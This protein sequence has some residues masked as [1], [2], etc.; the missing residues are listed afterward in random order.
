MIFRT[1]IGIYTIRAI[2]TT[3]ATRVIGIPQSCDIYIY[4]YTLRVLIGGM[5]ATESGKRA[6]E[7]LAELYQYWVPSEKIL[8]TS[9]WSSEL[10]KLV[11][12]AFLAQRISS[13]NSVSAL[14]ERTGAD[15]QQVFFFYILYLYLFLSTS[16]SHRYTYTHDVC[17][18]ISSSNNPNNHD[19]SDNPDIAHVIF[20]LMITR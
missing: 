3:R 4:I 2:R 19:H 15:V 12:N 14:C 11:A 16:F 6:V 1:Q 18:S 20:T 10:A 7:E 17:D 8:T 5:L 9:L 13:I